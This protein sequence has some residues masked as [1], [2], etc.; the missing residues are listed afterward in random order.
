MF[1]QTPLTI[2]EVVDH[3]RALA[4]SII[5]IQHPVVK[6]ILMFILWDRLDLLNDTLDMEITDK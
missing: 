4:F 3:C 5:E 1:D 6:E 2:E